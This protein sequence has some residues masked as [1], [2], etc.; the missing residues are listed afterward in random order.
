MT[1]Y[2][3]DANSFTCP[4]CGA[5]RPRDPHLDWCNYEGPEDDED[6]DGR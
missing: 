5:E 1:V 3:Q 4:V 2:D 6:D